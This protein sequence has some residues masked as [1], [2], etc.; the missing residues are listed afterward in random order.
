M[1]IRE[2]SNVEGYNYLVDATNM[3][4]EAKALRKEGKAALV[5]SLF[6]AAGTLASAAA[7]GKFGKSLVGGAAS[8]AKAPIPRMRPTPS[9]PIPRPRPPSIGYNPLMRSRYNMGH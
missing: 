8:T 2:N 5:G 7:G 6:D 4:A 9:A 1:T 3:K